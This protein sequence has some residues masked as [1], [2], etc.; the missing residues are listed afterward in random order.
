MTGKRCKHGL[1]NRKQGQKM[2]KQVLEVGRINLRGNVFDHGWFEHI[3][4]KN[5]KPNMV[6]IAILG[7]VFYWYKPTEVRDEETNEI[8]YKQ[9][10][11]ADMLQ[12]SYQQLADAFGFTK[13]QVKDAC[14]YLKEKEL[15]HIEFRTITVNGTKLN[16]VM[17]VEPKTENIKAISKLYMPQNVTGSYDETEHPPTVERNRVPRQNGTPSYDKTEQAPTVERGTNTESTTKN[18]TQ[19]STET[20][21][22]T[23][24]AGGGASHNVGIADIIS[25]WENNGFGINNTNAKNTLLDYVNEGFTYEVLLKALVIASEQGKTNL[26]YVKGILLKWE[27]N[28]VFTLDKVEAYNKQ[29]GA[30]KNA[31]NSNAADEAKK[32][33]L[34]F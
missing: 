3:K 9:K 33:D 32:Y 5:G 18:S 12:K 30:G 23:N 16:N 22:T 13:R 25:F 14:D 10:F 27:Q 1:N 2:N 17:Y 7:E 24:S 19:S 29:K 21:T 28:E 34:P 26:A 20:T 31:K 15:L 11:K 8:H 6:A 4:L